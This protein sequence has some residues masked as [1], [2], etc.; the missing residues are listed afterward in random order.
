M[1]PEIGRASALKILFAAYNKGSIAL[2]A[3][4]YGAAQH[5]GVLE[6]L[7]GQFTHRGLSVEKIEMQMVRAAPKAWRWIAEMDE[8]SRALEDAGMPGEF[9]QGAGKVYGRLKD[10]KDRD[11]RLEDVLHFLSSML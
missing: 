1:G 7:K 11:A 5:Y 3:S 10:L 8:I 2:F 9:H 4:L 6:E